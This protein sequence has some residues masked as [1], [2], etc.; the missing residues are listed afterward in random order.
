MAY[1]LIYDKRANVCE[2]SSDTISPALKNTNYFGT[3][4]QVILNTC[5]TY[6]YSCTF[7][8]SFE[9]ILFMSLINFLAR[10]DAISRIRQL[11]R[12]A[13]RTFKDSPPTDGKAFAGILRAFPTRPQSA[14][15]FR[16]S[17]AI[18]SAKVSSRQLRN[19][20]Y[21]YAWFF[22]QQ[23]KYTLFCFFV[24]RCSVSNIKISFVHALCM[25]L[26]LCIM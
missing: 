7:T 26:L 21:T 22:F 19:G 12:E 23:N 15:S 6:K 13:T 11:D 17:I 5:K 2:T 3:S 1:L 18:N 10:R 9:F 4:I 8:V 16:P 20:N 24:E 14:L 25:K